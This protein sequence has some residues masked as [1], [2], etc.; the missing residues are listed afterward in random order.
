MFRRPTVRYGICTIL[1]PL[2]VRALI[3][4][5]GKI[6][7]FTFVLS[8]AIE[9]LGSCQCAGDYEGRIDRRE[10]AIKR[11]SARLHVKKVI[12]ETLVARGVGFRPLWAIPE[13]AKR[14]Q[15]STNRIIT[16]N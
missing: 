7:N 1:R 2:P 3:E 6:S 14:R 9:I 10:F 8:V 13:E 15:R 12:I 5:R 16:R 11:T 4:G